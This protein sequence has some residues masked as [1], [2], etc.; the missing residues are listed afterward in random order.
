MYFYGIFISWKSGVDDFLLVCTWSNFRAKARC[1]DRKQLSM[2]GSFPKGMDGQLRLALKKM[3][4]RRRKPPSNHKKTTQD[5][6]ANRLC[7]FRLRNDQESRH[8]KPAQSFGSPKKVSISDFAI[9]IV[10]G[11]H[12]QSLKG[13]ALNHWLGSV[14]QKS[15]TCSSAAVW[16]WVWFPMEVIPRD[17]PAL[18]FV[19]AQLIRNVLHGI[20]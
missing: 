12:W 15:Q 7:I 3:C 11:Y 20:T 5:G 1:K 14:L 9:L 19:Q 13:S 17:F 6:L 8:L 10:V 2:L 16:W 18:K 4:S